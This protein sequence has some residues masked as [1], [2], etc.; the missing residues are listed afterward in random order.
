MATSISRFDPVSTHPVE[1][2]ERHYRDVHFRFAR[3]LLRGKPQVRSYHTNR[4][5]AQ[6]DLNGDW[7]Q[8]PTAW[9]FV[10]L[11]FEPGR[12]LELTQDEQQTIARDH[13]NCLRNLRSCPVEEEV[14]LDEVRGQTALDKYLVEL[15]R[16]PESPPEEAAAHVDGLVTGL[17]EQARGAFGV[18]RITVHRVLGEGETEPMD[19]AGQ[20]PTGRMLAETTK[21]AYVEV[22]V[23][24]DEWGDEL[25][26][27]PR[28]RELL[29]DPWFGIANAYR[30]EERCGIDRR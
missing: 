13:P 4:V 26:A 30:V 17:L 27:R 11:R 16:R 7:Q 8:R 29:R 14:L 28:V 19:E 20:R 12:G 25:F 2:S 23:D 24:H 9:R 21:L 22:Y 10:I 18:R 5:L 15:D 1:E 3:H 6:H